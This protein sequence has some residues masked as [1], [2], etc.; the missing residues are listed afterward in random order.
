MVDDSTADADAL[1]TAFLVMGD[2]RGMI[3]AEKAEI[4]AF[5]LL[6]TDDGV[7]ERTSPAFDAMVTR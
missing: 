3:L 5:F 1:A 6:R 4:A 2:E 7:M